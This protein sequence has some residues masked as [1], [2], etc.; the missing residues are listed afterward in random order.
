M[1][2]MASSLRI[3]KVSVWSLDGEKNRGSKKR[4]MRE[5]LA[6]VNSQMSR[7]ENSHES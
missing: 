4:I 3:A 5:Y 6:G 1:N 7:V 2:I